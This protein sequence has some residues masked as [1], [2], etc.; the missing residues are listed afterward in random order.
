MT[1]G[2]TARRSSNRSR[3]LTSER[4]NVPRLS[5][6]NSGDM[7]ASPRTPQ[8][9][10]PLSP[11]SAVPAT[12]RGP[13]PGDECENKASPRFGTPRVDENSP[14]ISQISHGSL[15]ARRRGSTLSA[16]GLGS[17]RRHKA[18]A[19]SNGSASASNKRP[20]PLLR[21]SHASPQVRRPSASPPATA[22]SAPPPPTQSSPSH[23]CNN[24]RS[25]LSCESSSSA[26]SKSSAENFSGPS[27]VG[28]N[29]AAHYSSQSSLAPYASAASLH[30]PGGYTARTSRSR[31]AA[32]ASFVSVGGG[33]ETYRRSST[34]SSH[35][36]HLPASS[37]VQ[38]SSGRSLPV[39]VE[40]DPDSDLFGGEQIEGLCDK[41]AELVRQM[42]PV[43]VPPSSWESR[44]GLPPDWASNLQ[45]A[46]SSTRSQPWSSSPGPPKNAGLSTSPCTPPLGM[47]CGASPFDCRSSP[48]PGAPETTHVADRSLSKEVA[49]AL[50]E[51][52]YRVEVLER[53]RRSVPAGSSHEAFMLQGRLETVEAEL[54]EV[55]GEL[56]QACTQMTQMMSLLTQHCTSGA[57]GGA[58]D[59]V[60]SAPTTARSTR[61]DHTALPT[62]QVT[63]AAA[64][65][66][67]ATAPVVEVLVSGS[68]RR[69]ARPG[70]APTQVHLPYSAR[71]ASYNPAPVLPNASYVPTSS[72]ANAQPQ[73]G[74]PPPTVRV[75]QTPIR[76][77][78]SGVATV[79]G[80]SAQWQTLAWR[81]PSA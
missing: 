43:A 67:T 81:M 77:I 62:G 74:T 33:D 48:V 56:K 10:N 19:G 23:P 16:R 24:S 47:T 9:R 6:H 58:S 11:R 64:Q 61:Q 8:E 38:S 32:D 1:H 72:H 51:M 18:R 52:R 34:Y 37:P 44:C 36:P 21:N 12:P 28:E 4:V 5:L 31:T 80:G 57:L 14:D 50:H 70:P 78:T 22:T 73:V 65:Q 17:S 63:P 54:K 7:Q 2:A 27:M 41:A 71:S 53:E 45:T 76:A 29:V 40:L 35:D 42:G 49:E 55:R 13:R 20:N 66:M 69:I 68:P 3:S 26:C 39:Q 15:S 30:V 79:Q 59:A 46:R 25:R 60:S 75:H